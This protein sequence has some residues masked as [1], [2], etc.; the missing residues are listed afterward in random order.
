MTVD[1]NRTRGFTLIELLVVIAIIGILAALLLPALGKARTRARQVACVNVLRQW[2]QV[3]TTYAGDYDEWVNLKLA[4]STIT[5]LAQGSPYEPYF[6]KTTLDQWRNWR[7]CPGDN[8]PATATGPS[9]SYLMVR[10]GSVAVGYRLS[11]IRRP[12]SAITI[13]DADGTPS[14]PWMSSSADLNSYVKDILDRHN[15]SINAAFCDGH[16]EMLN[17]NDLSANW[18]STYSSAN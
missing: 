12:S 2:G 16:V 8:R 7:H 14:N 11:D 13:L 3:I 18:T 4:P 10:Y 15:K 1:R 5:W 6:A 17:W 9:I